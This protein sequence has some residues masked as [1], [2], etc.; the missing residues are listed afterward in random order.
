[1]S[2]APGSVYRFGPFRYDSAH[3]LLY[4]N[5]VVV[6]LVPKAADTLQALLERRGQVVGK[7][8]LMKAVWPDCV[9]EDVGLARNVSLLRK[10]LGDDAEVYIETIPKRGYRFTA[11]V[12]DTVSRRDEAAPVDAPVL[13]QNANRADAGADV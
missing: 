10:T 5:D 12:S 7:A 4:R 13:H 2:Q 1:M 9:V 8:E 3:R 6:P 11:D